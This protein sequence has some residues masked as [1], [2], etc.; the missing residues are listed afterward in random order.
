MPPGAV[1]CTGSPW[2]AGLRAPSTCHI[3]NKIA[4]AQVQPSEWG[5]RR[6]TASHSPCVFK[7]HL[8]HCDLSDLTQHFH[9]QALQWSFQHLCTSWGHSIFWPWPYWWHTPTLWQS[10]LPHRLPHGSKTTPSRSRGPGKARPSRG[11]LGSP[12]SFSQPGPKYSQVPNA[13]RVQ[14]PAGSCKPSL[15]PPA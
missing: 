7:C 14:R 4:P 1:S 9:V 12:G 2:L 5:C 10:P 8:S 6:G 15:S 3:L 11:R 13:A